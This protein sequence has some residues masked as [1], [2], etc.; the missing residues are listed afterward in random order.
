VP[1]ELISNSPAELRQRLLHA[2]DIDDDS[3][4]SMVA[5]EEEECQQPA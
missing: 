5:S 4:S 2:L 3:S 1:P